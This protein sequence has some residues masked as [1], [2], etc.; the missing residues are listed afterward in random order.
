MSTINYTLRVDENDKKD[1]EAIFKSLGMTLA[2]GITIYLK[3]VKR[4]KKIPFELTVTEHSDNATIPTRVTPEEKKE[5]FMA[6]DGILTGYSVDL[7]TERE[8][9]LLSI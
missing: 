5:A 8:K 9:R 7:D 6:L 3:A 1:A 4:Q 2:T